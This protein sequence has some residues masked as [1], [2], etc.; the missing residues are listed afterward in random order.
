MT[1]QPASAP[2]QPSPAETQGA[3]PLTE[4]RKGTERGNGVSPLRAR[5]APRWSR[6]N[7][8]LLVTGIL[9]LLV[10]GIGAAWFLIPGLH[11]SR[12]DLVLHTV[13]REDIIQTIVERGE[14]QSAD[15]HDI[16]NRV[17]HEA[18]ATTKTNI[19]WVI[20]D[21]S[22]V[23]VAD[24]FIVRDPAL[25]VAVGVP[26]AL[27]V[28]KGD[29]LMLLDSA[30]LEDL[31][32]TQGITRDKAEND[33]IFAKATL[34]VTL[35][36]NTTDLATAERKVEIARKTLEEYRDGTYPAN[37]KD[38]NSKILKAEGDLEQNKDYTA[39]V[40]R[41]VNKKFMSSSQ[42]QAAHSKLLGSELDLQTAQENK[43][44]LVGF[45]AP[46]LMKQYQGD[47]DDTQG[48]LD[49]LRIST[50][51]QERKDRNDFKTKQAIF[52]Q[53]QS[54]YDDIKEEI[55]KCTISAPKTGLVVYYVSQQA[56]RGAGQ[57]QAIVAEGE[58]VFLGQK[59]MQMPD[60]DHMLVNTRIHEALESKVKVGQ[61]ARVRPHS[62]PGVK[63]LWGTVKSKGNVA[64]PQDWFSGDVKVYEAMI[65]INEED[66]KT[67]PGTLKPGM[68]A[69]VT[70][71]TD[72]RVYNVLAV[73]VQAIVR[74]P[75]KQMKYKVFVKTGTGI[76]EKEVEVGLTNEKM[77][78]IKSGLSEDD[79]V[80]LNVDVLQGEGK[81]KEK[82]ATTAP[83]G[84]GGGPGSW[85][86]P[87]GGGKQGGQPTP[88]GGA[89]GQSGGGASG[90]SGGAPGGPG[91]P[92][93]PGGGPGVRPGG[94]G[95][96]GTPPGGTG[97]GRGASGG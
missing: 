93:G 79:E 14:L 58:Q 65:E 32:R 84:P 18:L 82:G 40:D 68:S 96:L 11:P 19:K 75:G 4:A 2:P 74:V 22:Y 17:N 66:L 27:S 28:K 71:E 30:K 10:G 23:K 73:P 51:A 49:A 41:M 31:L 94:G 95:A 59:L 80:V 46:K 55:D 39:Y 43:R 12:P 20:D 42:A 50:A 25:A 15:N 16:Y 86:G 70:I 60:L 56:R 26:G 37:L 72:N 62:F 77:V 34:E 67:L 81:S 6:R 53:E 61:R 54:K 33:Y 92:S 8:L 5:P 29:T 47:L 64:A 69:E 91:A 83:G 36:K 90:Q 21:G 7:R 97:G 13:K 38:L 3:S 24:K 44:V 9:V 57:Q 48:A 1:L 78:E 45:T 76:E 63:P 88:P 85:Q 35:K 89:S 87:Q 52:E